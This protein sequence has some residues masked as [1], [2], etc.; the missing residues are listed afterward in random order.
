MGISMKSFVR[1]AAAL[2]FAFGV[3]P[4]N[5]ADVPVQYKAAP[6]FNWTG[7]YGGVHAGYVSAETDGIASLGLGLSEANPRGGFFGLTAGYNW[8]VSRNWVVGLEADISTGNISDSFL[9]GLANTETKMFG[10]FRARAGYN[11]GRSMLY[12]TGGLAWADTEATLLILTDKQML[13]GWTLG[14]GYEWAISPSWSAKLEYL[15][16]DLGN[17]NYFAALIP[18]GVSVGA[19]SHTYK[20]GVNYRFGL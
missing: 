13:M 16:T 10:T 2:T 7:F 12:V 20:F 8:Q 1:I 5:A 3:L 6:V 11:F 4:A 17:E 14:A 9:F 15:Y 19:N 18:G